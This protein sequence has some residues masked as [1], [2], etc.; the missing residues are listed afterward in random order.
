MKFNFN[1]C[2]ICKARQTTK[3]RPS[4]RRQNLGPSDRRQNLGHQ[5]Q[6]FRVFQHHSSF[7]TNI[8]DAISIKSMVQHGTYPN[9]NMKYKYNKIIGLPNHTTRKGKQ[10]TK[11]EDCVREMILPYCIN[12]CK[13]QVRSAKLKC[14]VVNV[15]IMCSSC[16]VWC[17][18]RIFSYVW[19]EQKRLHE[20]NFVSFFVHFLSSFVEISLMLIYILVSF[21]IIFVVCKANCFCLNMKNCDSSVWQCVSPV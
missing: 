1:I 15:C 5:T 3:Y 18:V 4:D 2:S 12:L 20:E 21:T 11:E 10:R 17:E 7:S 19:C 6:M 16:A 13:L 8:A 14:D 9:T